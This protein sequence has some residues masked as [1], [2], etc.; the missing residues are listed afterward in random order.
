M[1]QNMEKLAGFRLLEETIGIPIEII[2]NE[3]EEIP[4]YEDSINT[5]Q[6]IVFQIK[7]EEPD[8]SAVGVLL[9]LAFM[10]FSF[11]APRGM[12]QIEYDPN[13]EWTLGHFLNGLKYQ[14]GS[15]CFSAD[16]QSG[17]LMKTDIV[18]ECGGKV[19]IATRNRG[20]GAERWLTNL[21]GK[22]HIGLE[23]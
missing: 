6:T 20:R 15:L 22:K 23:T 19:T 3:Y 1:D 10:S 4:G 16:Y 21:G 13:E 9:A 18:F 17:R 8:D 5:Y 12:S 11:S 2:S 14:H 7:E